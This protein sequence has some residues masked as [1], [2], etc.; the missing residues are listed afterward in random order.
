MNSVAQPN[1]APTP[2]WHLW[3]KGNE[4]PTSFVGIN[5]NA[6]INNIDFNDDINLKTNTCDANVIERNAI[7]KYKGG[8][9]FNINGGI[10]NP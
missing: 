9:H 1:A 8:E 10:P 7:T 4:Q 5:P 2:M 6:E 3:G